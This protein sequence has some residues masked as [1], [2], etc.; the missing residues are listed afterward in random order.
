M[1][2]SATFFDE[3]LY[4]GFAIAT[5]ARLT[6]SI[7]LAMALSLAAFVIAHAP[8]WSWW[9][10]IHVAAGGGL[11]TCLFAWRFDLWANFIAHAAIDSVPLLF[12]PLLAR[13]AM[14]SAPAAG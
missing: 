10:L 11:L 3:F 13:G 9:Q 1:F 2:V 4:R 7:A 8:G 14:R 5:I 12:F 6:G